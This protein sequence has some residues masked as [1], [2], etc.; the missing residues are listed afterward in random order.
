[1]AAG[2]ALA[3]PGV[4][5]LRAAT[6][7]GCLVPEKC[8]IG[9]RSSTSRM[10]RGPDVVDHLSQGNLARSLTR[11]CGRHRQPMVLPLNGLADAIAQLSVAFGRSRPLVLVCSFDEELGQALLSD[12]RRLGMA[13][14]IA[15]SASGC[16]RVATAIGPDLLLLDARFPVSLERLLRSHPATAGMAVVRV[17]ALERTHPP[18]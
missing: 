6:V 9:W 7:D 18:E 16:L 3:T 5:G 1:M 15:R 4:F 14:C 17:P 10:R 8:G 13:A 11:R 2:P 12:V